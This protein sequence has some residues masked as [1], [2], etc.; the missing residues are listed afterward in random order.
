MVCGTQ[1]GVVVKNTRGFQRSEDNSSVGPRFIGTTQSG[2]KCY[3][4]PNLAPDV[5]V[6]GYKGSN[7]LD[8]G[9]RV[10]NKAKK[11]A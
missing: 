7:M 9:L 4:A 2:I 3:V 11:V 5:F 1:V 8:A 10:E 6:M